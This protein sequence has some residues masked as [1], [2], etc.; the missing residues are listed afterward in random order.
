MH[1]LYDRHVDQLILCTIYGVCKIIKVAPEVTFSR[2]IDCYYALN[3]DRESKHNDL[4][5]R[6][7]KLD[8]DVKPQMP[9]GNKTPGYGNVIHLYNQ[10]YVPSMKTHLLR[11]QQYDFRYMQQHYFE[12]DANL[13]PL[14]NDMIGALHSVT[15]A[16][17]RNTNVYVSTTYMNPVSPY[18]PYLPDRANKHRMQTAMKYGNHFLSPKT[19]TIYNFGESSTSD[20]LRVNQTVKNGTIPSNVPEFVRQYQVK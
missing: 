1:L 7:V 17:V 13:P 9:Q 6:Y 4:I 20:L 18:P 5:I 2:I 14:P 15:P 19:R 16:R 3:P 11:N 10:I 12:N 8:D